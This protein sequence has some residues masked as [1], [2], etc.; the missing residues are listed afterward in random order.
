MSRIAIII[1][2]FR[3]GN[4]VAK[5]LAAIASERAGLARSIVVYVVDN[6]SGDDSVRLISDAIDRE[7]WAAWVHLRLSPR[8]DGFSAGN[9]LALREI[10]SD[11]QIDYIYFLNPDACDTTRSYSSFSRLSRRMAQCRDCGELS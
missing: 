4:L 3:T 6:N 11:D 2:N 9:N 10:L 5:S 1:V 8:N 7:G